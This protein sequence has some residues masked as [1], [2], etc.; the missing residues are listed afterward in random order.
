MVLKDLGQF[1][2]RGNLVVENAALAALAACNSAPAP[3]K[4]VPTHTLTVT[5][6]PAPTATPTVTPTPAAPGSRNPTVLIYLTGHEPDTLDPQIDYTSAGAG[7][8]HNIYETLVTYDKTNPAKFVS[9]LA[10][11]VPEAVAADDGSVTYTFVIPDG[12]KF[13][14]GGE[15]SAED[16][17]YSLWRLALLGRT[18]RAGSIF[19]APTRTPGFHMVPRPDTYRPLWT[20]GDGTLDTEQY[21]DFYDTYLKHATVGQ[22]AAF[23]QAHAHDGVAGLGEG[24]QH[25][26]VGLGTGVGLDV[27]SFGAEQLL[28]TVDGQLLGHVHVFAAAVVALAGIALGVLVG[29]LA[30][31]RLHHGRRGVVLGSDQL[32]VVF[33]ALVLLL[34]GGPDFG[35]HIGEG[36]GAAIKHDGW[37]LVLGL[38]FQAG[39]RAL[40]SNSV[41]LSRAIGS[42]YGD[43]A[44]TAF[45]AL[46]RKHIGFVVDYTTGVATKNRAK[47]DKAVSDLLGY[48]TDFGAFL[49][50]ACP[51]L[52]TRVVAD[53]V[54]G[55]DPAIDASPADLSRFDEAELTRWRHGR[56]LPYGEGLAFWALVK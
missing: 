47:Q 6:T 36:R 51:S 29:Q 56:S 46:W 42:V 38:E 8:L 45:L 35:V 31:L 30:A 18:D 49:S 21:L 20:R 39:A 23:G 52:P 27:G 19:D 4:I 54:R 43:D 16:V 14:Q 3:A 41:A 17:A 13:H 12:I 11:Y 5:R 7:V 48:A 37:W 50:A 26:L 9:L 44:G 28:Q 25:G 32:D 40:D 1:A 55:D 15:V 10:E 24:H 2:G 22:V 34:N 53:L 33:L